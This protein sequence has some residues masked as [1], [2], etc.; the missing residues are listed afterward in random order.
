[1]RSPVGEDGQQIT[2]PKTPDQSV[3]APCV[4]ACS[5]SRVQLP[6]DGS[7]TCQEVRL[8]K[9]IKLNRPQEMIK[10]TASLPRLHP[11]KELK[12]RKLNLR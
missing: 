5:C 8:I 2:F 9:Q 1:M 3:R 7:A 4:R 12:E 6:I 10:K 11:A